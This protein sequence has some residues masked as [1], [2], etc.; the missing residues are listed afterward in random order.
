M[1]AN[2]RQVFLGISDYD[3]HVF[4]DS[5]TGDMAMITSLSNQRML[6]GAD[7]DGPSELAVGADIVSVNNRLK[8]KGTLAIASGLGEDPY[9]GETAVTSFWNRNACND[10]YYALG[11]VAVGKSNAESTLDVGGSVSAEKYLGSSNT[12]PLVVG[13]SVV[14]AS[15][16]AYDLGSSNLRFRDLFLSGNTIHIGDKTIST[17]SNEILI[18]AVVKSTSGFMVGEVSVVDSN[19]D[20]N[21]SR[22]AVSSTSNPG[23]VQLEDDVSSFCNDRA[24]TA[25]AVRLAYSNAESRLPL[26][27]GTLSGNLAIASNLTVSGDF[28]VSGTVLAVDTETLLV[29]DNMVLLNSSNV[30]LTGMVSGIEVSRGSASN[31]QFV[32]VEDTESFKVGAAG[33]LQAVATRPDSI[34]DRSIPYWDSS[35]NWLAF[36]SNVTVSSAGTVTATRFVGSGSNLTALNAGA[37]TWGVLSNERTTATSANEAGA[38]VARDASGGFTASNVTVT[39]ISLAGNVA[40]TGGSRFVGTTTDNN[41][42]LR[43]NNTDRITLSSNGNMGIGTASP[44]AALHVASTGAM[45]VP[46]GTTAEIPASPVLGMLRFN[47]TTQKLQFYSSAG[48]VSVG[49]IFASGGTVTE[50]GGYRIHTFLSSDTFTVVSGGSMEYLI[51]AGGGGG[52]CRFGGGGGAGGLLYSASATVTAG[53]YSIVVGGGGTGGQT[54]NTRGSSGNN[55][56]FN[57]IVATGGGGGASEGQTALNGGSGGG[58]SYSTGFQTPGTGTSGQGNGGGTGQFSPRVNG[59]GGGAGAAGVGS[60]SRPDGGIGLQYSISGNAMYYAGGGG[61]ADNRVDAGGF[62]GPTAGNGGLGGG[63]QGGGGEGNGQ[64]DARSGTGVSGTA[65]TGGGGG[66]GSY[67]PTITSGRPGGNGGSGIVIIRYLL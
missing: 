63:G 41:L 52:G 27:G 56:S 60:G 58:A 31:Y 54:N 30:P 24:A 16:E 61:G 46:T 18:D 32:F 1:G 21:T 2:E 37:L 12:L 26:S 47:T 57:A 44:Q 62:G 40:L 23:I 11:K 10:L 7:L 43:T 8:I 53:T 51:V 38:I 39:G 64:A 35:S 55:S 42:S 29:K 20:V 13:T 49:G 65:N 34:L 9:D 3:G 36:D 4:S 66:G 48:W 17:L 19:G 22:L 25:D 14:P 59:G 28:T 50:T 45:I 6:F 5:R 33:E 67:I 15:N